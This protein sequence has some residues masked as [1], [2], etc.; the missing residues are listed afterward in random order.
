MRQIAGIVTFAGALAAAVAVSAQREPVLHCFAAETQIGVVARREFLDDRGFVVKEI[1]YRSTELTARRTCAEDTLR[2]YS[3][4]T[5]TRDALGRSVV[6][7]E[8]SPAGAVERVVR[9]E[10]LGDSMQPSRDIWAS[11]QG[12]RRYEIRRPDRGRQTHL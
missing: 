2:V 7:T 10:Y 9:H 8:M 3:V 11:P 6:E 12:E 4:R 5:F 1:L